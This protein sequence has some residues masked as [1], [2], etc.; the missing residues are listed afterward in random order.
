MVPRILHLPFG[1]K[2]FFLFGPRQ[3]GKSTLV[4]HALANRDHVEIDLLNEIHYLIERF[5]DKV[6]FVLIGYQLKAGH[7][8]ISRSYS[9]VGIAHPTNCPALSW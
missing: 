6:T 4:K 2:S 1:R 3:V 8:V 7:L 9:R 5:N